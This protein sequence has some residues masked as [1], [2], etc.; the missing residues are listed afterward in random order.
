MSNCYHLLQNPFL[1]TIIIVLVF[2]FVVK[3]IIRLLS[4]EQS[5][6]RSHLH[7]THGEGILKEF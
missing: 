3:P 7:F 2:V 6:E 4:E 1:F 5:V